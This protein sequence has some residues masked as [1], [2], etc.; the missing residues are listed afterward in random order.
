M[1]NCACAYSAT[2]EHMH[3]A[4]YKCGM[5]ANESTLMGMLRIVLKDSPPEV[6]QFAETL[7]DMFLAQA[8]AFLDSSPERPDLRLSTGED[9]IQALLVCAAATRAAERKREQRV[10]QPR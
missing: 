1:S 7:D 8:R 10:Q 6:R 9:G 5:T 4:C 3:L 2:L